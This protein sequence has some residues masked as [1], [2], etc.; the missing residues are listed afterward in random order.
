MFSKTSLFNLWAPVCVQWNYNY[1]Y[2]IKIVIQFI[3]P[4]S[5]L[6]TQIY[7]T[8]IVA[9]FRSDISNVTVLVPV[10]YIYKTLT[11]LSLR[12]QMS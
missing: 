6:H 3:L 4:I 10:P 9:A 12:L 2:L 5:E 8:K 7:I 11:L 1:K